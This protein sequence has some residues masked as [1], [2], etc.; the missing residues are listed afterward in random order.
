MKQ[1]AFANLINCE[2]VHVYDDLEAERHNW[3]IDSTPTPWGKSTDHWN[4]LV[5]TEDAHDWR[6][7]A[8]KTVVVHGA[9]SDDDPILGQILEGGAV[10]VFY[11]QLTGDLARATP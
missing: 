1:P 2:V 8:G 5:P 4:R 11:L 9:L 10:E 3:R 6:C 7:C